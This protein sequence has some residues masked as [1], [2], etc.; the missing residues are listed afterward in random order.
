MTDPRTPARARH[1]ARSAPLPLWG[2]VC[3]FGS[4]AAALLYEVVWSK[5]LAY[6]LG[7]STHAVATVVAAFLAGLALGARVLGTWLARRG[8]GGRVYAGLE[9]GVGVLGLISLPV[10]R[11]LDPLV[12]ELYRALG[13]ESAAFAVVRFA[14]LFALLLPPAALMGATLPVLVAHFEHDLVGPALARLYALN[15]FGAVTGSFV[16]GFA[17]MPG[18][19][20]TGTV[21]VAAALN[22]VVAIL[23]WIAS[24]PSGAAARPQPG[25]ARAQPEPARPKPQA[26]T[27]V[28]GLARAPRALFAVL[29]ALSGAAAL[30][31]QIAWVRL[32]S[33]MFGSSVYSFSAVLAVYLFGL[34]LG[35]AVVSP[36]MDRGVSL[37]WFARAQLALAAVAALMMHAFSRLPQ[38]VLDLGT[39]SGP[40]WERLIAGEVGLTAFLLIVPCGLLGAVF[41]I[42]TRL[43]Q[44]G[45]GGHAAGFAYAVNTAGTIAGSLAAGFFAVPTWGVQGTHLAALLLSLAIGL[46]TIAIAR[47]RS[48]L[49]GRD[50]AATIAAALVVAVAAVSA[51]RW[52][53]SLMSAGIFRPRQAQN[54]ALAARVTPGAGSDVWRGSRG[55]KVLFYREGINGSVLVGTDLEGRERWLR[56]SGKVDASTLDMETQV[57]LGLI[58]AALADSGARTLIIGLGSG[59]TAAA[60][61]AAGAGPTE[62]VELEPAVVEASRFFHGPGEDPLDDPRTRLL[63]GDA[64]THLAHGAGRY[65]LIISEP[66]NPW[67]AGINNLFTVDFYRR[68]RSRLESGGVFAQWMQTYELTPETFASLSASFLEVFGE[69]EVFSV[70]RAYDLLLV[71]MPE[72]R[73]LARERLGAP[74]ALRV[75][76]RAKLHSPVELAGH[77]AERL[78][79]LRPIGAGAPLNTDDRP[80]VEYRAPR[81][82]IRVGRSPHAGPPAVS[83]LVPMA[84]RKPA[85]PLFAAWSDPEWYQARVQL[86]SAHGDVARAE[87][88]LSGAR[89]AGLTGLAGR[90]EDEIQAGV[91]RRRSLEAIDQ[92]RGLLSAGREEEGQQAL[93]RATDIDPTHG[94]AWLM[95]ADRRRL[96]GDSLGARAA[97]ERGRSDPETRGEAAGMTGMMELGRNPRAAAGYFREAQR[98]NPRLALNYLLEA[99]ALEAAGDHTGAADAVRRGLAEQPGDPQLTA[100]LARLGAR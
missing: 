98:L 12:G 58:P 56:V 96:S 68:V 91:R 5:Q 92:A 95:L 40:R 51:P 71:A 8:D 4:G 25:P 63:V 27:A 16:G 59:T 22:L 72:G 80:I 97:L 18:L 86:L 38:W 17:L 31:F 20:L 73:R 43:L 87:R 29:F 24:R 65:D 82:L 94:R 49:G 69:G 60:A 52:D 41:P 70:W 13:G 48:E 2:A 34:A 14:L 7:S 88:A 36:W 15:T 9:V 3:F 6:L 50:F 64:R 37:A 32:F 90:M 83:A 55:E 35:S 75:L 47:A 62:V 78:A 1:A 30:A 66:S 61:L 28:P 21:W 84:E 53:P 11:G 81:D 54:I 19:G 44:R 93:V 33:L 89:A 100:M 10:L 79:A 99:R 23:A 42:A 85:G 39:G 76:E 74:A 77:Y 46:A 57:I 45:D 67:I 26:A